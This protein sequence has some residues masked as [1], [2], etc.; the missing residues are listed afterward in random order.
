MAARHNLAV[1][2]ARELKESGITSNAVS[3]GVMHVE[4]VEAL[5]RSIAPKMGWVLSSD[6]I[7]KVQPETLSQ[8]ILK[9]SVVPKKSLVQSNISGAPSPIISAEQ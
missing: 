3:P 5:L 7:K 8:M 1:S 9:G 4:S 6:E 2:L